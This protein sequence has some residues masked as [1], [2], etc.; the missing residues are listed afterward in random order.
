MRKIYMLILAL[1]LSFSFACGGGGDNSGSDAAY[2]S[3]SSTAEVL[4]AS[5]DSGRSQAIITWNAVDGATQYNIYRDGD[6]LATTTNLYYLDTPIGEDHNYQIVAANGGGEFKQSNTVA[7]TS[8]IWTKQT[9]SEQIN[10]IKQYGDYIY[11]GGSTY[12]DTSGAELNSRDAFVGKYNQQGTSVKD[13]LIIKGDK[14]LGDSIIDMALSPQGD[15]LYVCGVYNSEADEDGEVSSQDAFIAKID[16]ATMS[17]VPGWPKLITIDSS[18]VN[19]AMGIGVDSKGNVFVSVDA[20]IA[21]GKPYILIVKYDAN[22]NKDLSKTIQA[23]IDS[24][25]LYRGLIVDG[26]DN[27]IVLGIM[28]GAYG[29][30]TL[31]DWNWYLG[32]FDNELNSLWA[33]HGV[34]GVE[35]VGHMAVDQS[36]NVFFVKRDDKDVTKLF[37]K[38][39]SANGSDEKDWL[40]DMDRNYALKSILYQNGSL[41]L[42]GQANQ[43]LA[44]EVRGNMLYIRKYDVSGTTPIFRYE[45]QLGNSLKVS[46]CRLDSITAAS[47]SGSIQIYG[48]GWSDLGFDGF[49]TSAPGASYLVRFNLD[50]SVAAWW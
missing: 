50:N 34:F 18:S 28:K 6:L 9:G 16:T 42:A 23:S 19:W 48:G 45:Q 40:D 32:K 14:N 41:Y 36:G 43:I 37:M 29:S 22:G 5:A 30:W 26:N 49:T 20:G 4:T 7:A 2:S 15:Y 44:G 17:L 21:K 35:L 39:I 38:I 10:V 13:K 25:P 27:V 47:V 8:T 24:Q 12:S 46:K 33:R 31:S 3:S 11:V 1:M